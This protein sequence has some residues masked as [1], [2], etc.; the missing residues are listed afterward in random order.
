MITR[1]VSIALLSGVTLSAPLGDDG[2]SERS[3][4]GVLRIDVEECQDALVAYR[5]ATADVLNNLHIY[6]QCVADSRGTDDCSGEFGGLQSAQDDFE[7]AVS[8]YQSDCN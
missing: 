2:N 5:S 8:S 6:G 3:S 7:T 4:A 1:L